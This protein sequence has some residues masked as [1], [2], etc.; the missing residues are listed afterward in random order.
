MRTVVIGYPEASYQE[1]LAFIARCDKL[2]LKTNVVPRFASVVNYQT[3]FEYLG[4]VPLLNLRAI[5]PESWPFAIKYALDRVVAGLLLLAFA[6][7]FAA[8]ALAVA[9]SSPAR[10]SSASCAPAATGASSPS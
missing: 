3:R 1:M 10:S 4:T 5:D 2:G 6:P 8:L 7:L 9:L